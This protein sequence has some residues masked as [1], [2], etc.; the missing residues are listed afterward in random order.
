VRT[1]S[2]DVFPGPVPSFCGIPHDDLRSSA[3]ARRIAENPLPPPGRAR[4]VRERRGD[5]CHMSRS[6]G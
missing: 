6:S 1:G 2:G 3:V 4:R 5:L